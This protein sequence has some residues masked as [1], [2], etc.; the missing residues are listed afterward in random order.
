MKANF[1]TPAQDYYN[2]VKRQSRMLGDYD[3]YTVCH[4]LRVARTSYF[5]AHLL[6][7]TSEQCRRVYYAANAHDIGKIG[8]PDSIL[9]KR[10][11][12]TADEWIIMKQHSA[13]GAGMLMQ[14]EP[15]EGIAYIVWCHHERYDGTGYPNRLTGEQIPLEARIIAVCDS[16]DAMKSKRAYRDSLPDKTCQNEIEKNIGVMY[17]PVVAEL[18]LENW[19]TMQKLQSV[20]I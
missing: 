14:S 10:G 4:S 6:G 2:M 9:H 5:I 8:I 16:F 1:S 3:L 20:D 19:Q 17:D 7:L 12:L 11:S 15:M 13:L 18:V